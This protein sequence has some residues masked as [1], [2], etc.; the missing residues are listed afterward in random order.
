MSRRLPAAFLLLPAVTF[1]LGT[2]QVYRHEWKKALIAARAEQLR[3]APVD[4]R[5]LQR[6]GPDAVPEYARV[7]ASGRFRRD[8]EQFLGPRSNAGKP[9]YMVLTPLEL[10]PGELVLVNRGW[11]P[12]AAFT[13][14]SAISA[15]KQA[16]NYDREVDVV[17]CVRHGEKKPWWQ[18]DRGAADSTI[19]A[20]RDLVGMAERAGTYTGFM[21]DRDEVPETASVP[22]MPVG[23]LA[24]SPLSNR[25]LEYIVT[26]YSLTAGQLLLWFLKRA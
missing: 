2:W 6:L 18:S 16:A 1:G 11:I 4:I 14:R 8:G 9:G 21:V 7:H 10:S 24:R 5:E 22:D 17:G 23:G 26:W 19:W 15:W 13:E 20:Y 3:A 12:M 25:H